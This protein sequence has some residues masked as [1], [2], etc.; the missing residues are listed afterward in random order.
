MRIFH[1]TKE[2]ETNHHLLEEQLEAL[3]EGV[4]KLIDRAGTTSGGEPTRLRTYAER[5]TE[6][7]QEHPFASIA[8]ALGLGYVTARIARRAS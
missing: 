1:A 8:I 2:S 3:K 4:R 6:T 7:I 5:A